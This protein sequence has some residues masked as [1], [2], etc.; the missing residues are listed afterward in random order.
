VGERTSAL[1]LLE[2]TSGNRL[3]APF[4]LELPLEDLPPNPFVPAAAVLT[5]CCRAQVRERCR[6]SGSC[7]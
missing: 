6:T 3:C 1:L 5:G 7:C 4:G 2:L